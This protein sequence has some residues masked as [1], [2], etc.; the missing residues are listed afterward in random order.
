[1]VQ[2][3]LEGRKTIT[4][5]VIK[6]QPDKI[7]LYLIRRLESRKLAYAPYKPDDILWIRETWAKWNEHYLY[8]ADDTL[9]DC[10]S[11]DGQAIQWQP[12]SNM[13]KK[14]ARIFIRVNKVRVERLHKIS[15]ADIAR[16]G[17]GSGKFFNMLTDRAAFRELWDCLYKPADLDKYGWKANPWVWVISFERCE[18]PMEQ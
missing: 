7:E 1:M 15:G 6:P 5:R 17:V 18:K 13:P 16:E 8:L 12:S 3:I 9:S 10:L 11:E 4:R 14:A 2:A